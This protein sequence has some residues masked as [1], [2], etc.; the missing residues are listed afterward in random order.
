M[1]WLG[2]GLTE[3][4]AAR[5]PSAGG[6]RC[7]TREL[8]TGPSETRRQGNSWTRRRVVVASR[9]FAA[10]RS[11]SHLRARRRRIVAARARVVWSVSCV[12]GKA[13][14]P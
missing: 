8:A 13:A 5:V 11:D 6:H 10:S 4:I 3:I 1:E 2:T 14:K 7:A 9:V 12:C